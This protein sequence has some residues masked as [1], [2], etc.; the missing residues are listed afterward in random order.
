LKF[1]GKY[2]IKK[3][4]IKLNNNYTKIANNKN[5]NT[6]Q[7]RGIWRYVKQLRR[8]ANYNYLLKRTKLKANLLS[9]TGVNLVLSHL[10]LEAL[11]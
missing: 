4:I 1:I 3:K 8:R 7:Q 6:S 9:H 5:I 11:A 2:Y 10:V